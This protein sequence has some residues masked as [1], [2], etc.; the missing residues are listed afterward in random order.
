VV[1]RRNA[2]NSPESRELNA[3]NSKPPSVSLVISGLSSAL[4]TGPPIVTAAPSCEKVANGDY[5]RVA[6]VKVDTAPE[7]QCL[8]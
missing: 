4:P 3:E 8:R 1:L 5:F 7:P 6:G 2:V